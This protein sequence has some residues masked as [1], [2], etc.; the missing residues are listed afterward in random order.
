MEAVAAGTYHSLALAT[1][2]GSPSTFGTTVA[3]PNE[4]DLSWNEYSSGAEGF[5]IDRAP[6]AGGIPGAWAQI[7][8]T[9]A[10]VTSYSDTTVAANT[11]YWYRVR[12]QNSCSDS[13]YA[14]SRVVFDILDDTWLSGSRTIQNPPTSSAWFTSSSGSLK[15]ASG[16][17]TLTVGS[18]VLI[19]TYFT[20]NSGSPPVTLNVGDTLTAAIS[21]IFNG[22][23]TVASSS[24]GF[25]IGL[26]DFADGSNSPLRVSSDGSFSSSSQGLNVAGYSLFQKMYTTFSDSTPMAIRKRITLSDASSPWPWPH[27]RRLV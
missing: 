25:R 1:M 5:E 21:L 23:P 3:A 11:P 19:Q 14:I 24:Q 17:M 18:S 13:P 8:A 22:L 4:I 9:D 12:A 27:T 6:D 15:A 10:S 16:A 20:P 26:Y 2:P 7:A